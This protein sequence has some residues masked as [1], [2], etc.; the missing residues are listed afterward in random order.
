M[1]DQRGT[2]NELIADLTDRIGRGA[3]ELA[4]L[5]ARADN[6]SE[7]ERLRGK[8]QGLMLVADWLRSYP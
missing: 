3:D 6:P 4:D 2:V 7:K 1:S 5:A 8:R